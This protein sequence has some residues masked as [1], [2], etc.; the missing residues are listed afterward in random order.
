MYE[1][2]PRVYGNSGAMA[3]R[4]PPAKTVLGKWGPVEEALHFP[5]PF[6]RDAECRLEKSGFS[7]HLELVWLCWLVEPASACDPLLAYR[8]QPV[9]SLPLPQDRAPSRIQQDGGLHISITKL[10]FLG[11]ALRED[12]GKLIQEQRSLA[13]TLKLDF[14]HDSHVGYLDTAAP[15]CDAVVSPAFL[16]LFNSGGEGWHPHI[17]F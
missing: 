5:Q 4:L 2:I 8:V 3:Y 15:G 1:L 13:C 6:T 17:F 16:A 10:S 11:S 7:C 9:E 14:N 12:L